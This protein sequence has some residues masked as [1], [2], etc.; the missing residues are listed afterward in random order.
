MNCCDSVWPKF[1]IY[2]NVMAVSA[3]PFELISVFLFAGR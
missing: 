1:D 2:C 3:F